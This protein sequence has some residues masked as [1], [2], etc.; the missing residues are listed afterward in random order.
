MPNWPCSGLN[1]AR[2][3]EFIHINDSVT[4]IIYAWRITPYNKMLQIELRLANQIGLIYF[5]RLNFSY[6]DIVQNLLVFTI[7]FS[8]KL[9][10][11]K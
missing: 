10:D 3:E 7:F 5:V 9:F 8:Q 11:V 6:F 1:Y 4:R 2:F